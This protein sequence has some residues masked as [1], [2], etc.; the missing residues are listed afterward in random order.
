MGMYGCVDKYLKRA[1]F[2]FAIILSLTGS[3]SKKKCQ[4]KGIF[5]A[6][7]CFFLE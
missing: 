3:T 2:F 6:V 7:L 5:S 1:T 4:G